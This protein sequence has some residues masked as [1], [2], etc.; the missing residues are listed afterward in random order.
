MNGPPLAHPC[1]DTSI[2]SV[3]PS[4]GN[5]HSGLIDLVFA[6]DPDSSAPGM[7]VDPPRYDSKVSWNAGVYGATADH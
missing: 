1:I 5:A 3:R 7:R 4:A 6:A 2:R